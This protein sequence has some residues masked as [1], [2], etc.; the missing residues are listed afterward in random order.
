M[1]KAFRAVVFMLVSTAL[2]AQGTAKT[3]SSGTSEWPNYGNDP[4]GMRYSPVTQINNKNV[5]KLQVAWTFHT[6]DISDG[7]G[8]RRRSGFESTPILVDGT[9]YVTTPFNR[10]IALDPATGKQR[11][12]FDPKID[13]TWQSGDGLINRGVATWLDAA[14]PQ[15]N[16]DKD[17]NVTAAQTCHRRIFEATIDARLVAVDAATGKACADFGNGGE[18]SLRDVE[19]FRAG[20]YHI[21]SPPAVV[22]DVVVTGSAIDDNSRSDMPS[23][24]VRAFNVRTGKLRWSWDPIPPNTSGPTTSENARWKSGAANA[25]SIM[26]VDPERHL[27]FIPTG[28]A[29]PD[30]FGG[31]RPGDNKWANSV[32]ALRAGSGDLV[33]GFQLVHHD[34]WD[35][36]VASPPLLATVEHDGRKMPVVI[37]GNKSGFLF[38][39]ERETGKPVFP[40]EERPV[41]KSDIPGEAASPT[42]PFPVAPPP[43]AKQRYSADDAWGIN[44]DERA[45][46][47]KQLEGLRLDGVFTPPSVNGILAVPGNIGGLNW[48]GYAFDPNVGLL[49]ANANNL[50]FKV[51]LI[52]RADF[53]D[54]GKRTNERISEDGEYGPQIGVPYAMFRRPMFSPK[55]IPCVPPPWG[56]LTAV[57]MVRGT[58]KWQVPLGSWHEGL[59]PGDISLGGPIVTAGG[60]VFIGGTLLDPYIRAFDSESG[61]ELWK[62]QLPAPGHATPM[63]YEIGGKQY[64]VIAAGGHAKIE[65]ESLSDAL[66][67]FAVP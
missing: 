40:I 8:E 58:I 4:G 47:R 6:G 49:F 18:V 45:A 15:L 51:R 53:D 60:L 22:D 32:V 5:T 48:S 21:T 2:F 33:W 14:A 57:D 17:E 12:A 38:V 42:Q 10:I 3:T 29:S 41:P 9:L 44:A 61:K 13:Q 35:Y 11:W 37:I 36:D 27:V 55:F 59:P 16:K 43:L 19:G 23:G 46:C 31:Q 1:K 67:A 66:I 62:A 7:K 25:W 39:L 56:T 52:P 64:V 20:R 63:T 65:Q 28:S 54:R 50:P 24:V 26:T 30:F 34:L